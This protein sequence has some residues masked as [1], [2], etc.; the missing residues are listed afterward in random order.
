MA[1]EIKI[2]IVSVLK[3]PDTGEPE[4]LLIKAPNGALHLA[5]HTTT[6]RK[7]AAPQSDQR[8]TPEEDALL[9]RMYYAFAPYSIIAKKLKRTAGACNYRMG[10]IR[11]QKKLP[12]RE[13][14]PNANE[15]EVA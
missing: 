11:Q 1:A 5:H 6:T 4:Y 3:N 12:A 7:K 2:P 9:E 14:V 10:L 13:A 15:Q 8:W